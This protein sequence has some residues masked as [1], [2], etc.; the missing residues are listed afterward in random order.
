MSTHETI[1]QHGHDVWQ[2]FHYSDVL[3]DIVA[4][5]KREKYSGNI[6]ASFRNS[7]SVPLVD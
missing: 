7:T 1:I 3:R 4:L 6:C 2:Y 5:D